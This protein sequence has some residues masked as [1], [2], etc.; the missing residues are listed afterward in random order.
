MFTVNQILTWF[1]ATH[2]IASVQG[3]IL[4]RTSQSNIRHK[5]FRDGGR[6]CGRCYI[7]RVARLA[8]LSDVI[9]CYS[10]RGSMCTDHA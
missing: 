1:R 2:V 8:D 4:D 9:D 10:S 3:H 7:L 5:S 6:L